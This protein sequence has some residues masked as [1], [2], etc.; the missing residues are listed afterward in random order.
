MGDDK[1]QPIIAI[2]KEMIAAG[3]TVF[4]VLATS[5]DFNMSDSDRDDFVSRIFCQMRAA[6]PIKSGVRR[7]S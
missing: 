5:L 2:T 7:Q 1:N 3:R 4:D 6:A